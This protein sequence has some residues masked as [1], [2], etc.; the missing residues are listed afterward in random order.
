[1]YRKIEVEWPDFGVMVTI[2]LL[3][4]ENPKLCDRFWQALPF[5]TVFMLSM[6]AGGIFK[7]PIPLTLSSALEEKLAFL[8]DEPV[9]TVVS[10]SGLA[11]LFIKYGTVV[12]PFRVP[13][14]GRILGEDL[15]K[16]RGVA[17][18]IRDAYFFTKDTNIATLKKKA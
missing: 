9:G 7:V 3:D 18:R 13:R 10:F 1:M 15:E 4:D 16:L 14:I 12:E 2:G 5:E 8:P 11:C 6:S 17:M